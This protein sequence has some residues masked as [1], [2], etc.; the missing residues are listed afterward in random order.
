[1]A[2]EL[3]RARERRRVFEELL[4]RRRRAGAAEEV[5]CGVPS[6]VTAEKMAASPTAIEGLVALQGSLRRSA[7]PQVEREVVGVA[8]SRANGCEYSIAAHSA[9]AESAGA[10]ADV[11]DALRAGAELPDARLRAIQDLTRDVLRNRGHI[12]TGF[13]AGELLDVLTQIAYTTLAN[14]VANVAGTPIDAAFR[15]P[16]GA[17]RCR[18]R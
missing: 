1:M 12:T 10:P 2:R 17:R 15:E 13:P 7:L 6:V 14:L 18:G 5:S 16:S 4:Q 9:F 11:V 8:V 3:P